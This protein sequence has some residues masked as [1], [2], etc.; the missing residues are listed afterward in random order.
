MKTADEYRQYAYECRRLAER[1]RT[2]EQRKAILN[3]AASW[4]KLVELER[5][6]PRKRPGNRG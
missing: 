6:I 3:I 5:K 4:N 2:P 1:A